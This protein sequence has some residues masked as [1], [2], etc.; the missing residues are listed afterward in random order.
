MKCGPSD[1]GCV[2]TFGDCG[3]E[4]A[5]ICYVPRVDDFSVRLYSA[6]G[7]QHIVNSSAHNILCYTISN[8][9][10]TAIYENDPN[11]FTGKCAAKALASRS[12]AVTSSILDLIASAT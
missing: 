10:K 6:L 4:A 9:I 5:E 3:S 11:H 2:Y 7:K 1:S 8:T 12:S